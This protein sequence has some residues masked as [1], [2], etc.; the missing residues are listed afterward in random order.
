MVIAITNDNWFNEWRTEIFSLGTLRSYPDEL[1]KLVNT[2][3]KISRVIGVNRYLLMYIFEIFWS[4]Y[5]GPIMPWK[6]S[7]RYCLAFHM[8]L[9]LGGLSP[10]T[11][12]L[13]KVVK[14]A[15]RVEK[16]LSNAI[17]V[18]IEPRPLH[19]YCETL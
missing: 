9:C 8:D 1:A 7:C 10:V 17:V 18:K 2:I 3:R 12:I 19:Q 13:I 6:A 4:I 16:T 5:F 14:E 15:R 11:C